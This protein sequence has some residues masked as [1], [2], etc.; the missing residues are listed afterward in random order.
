MIWAIDQDDQN[1]TSIGLL[2]S[3][4]NREKSEVYTYQG[5][6]AVDQAWS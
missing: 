1:G 4:L 2:G 5:N 3:D 6:A